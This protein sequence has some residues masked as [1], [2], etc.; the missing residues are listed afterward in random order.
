MRLPAGLD[1]VVDL[2]KLRDYC[3]SSSHPRGRHKARVFASVLGLT[4]TDAE[5]L[6]QRLLQA[7]S[8]EEASIG[9][10]DEY[11]DRYTVDFELTQGSRRAT[12]RSHW[13]IRRLETFPRLITCYVLLD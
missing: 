11:G 12:I 1:A 2:G 6:R 13:I 7:A 3:L 5:S 8:D 10:S 9:Q 4:Q